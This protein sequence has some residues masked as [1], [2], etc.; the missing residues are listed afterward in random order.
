[1]YIIGH[2]DYV[3]MPDWVYIPA[4]ASSSI[5]RTASRNSGP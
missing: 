2:I 3:N 4:P 1:M 5:C